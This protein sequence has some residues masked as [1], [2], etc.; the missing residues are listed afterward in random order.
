MTLSEDRRSQPAGLVLAG[1]GAPPALAERLRAAAQRLAALT[2]WPLRPFDPAL[3]PRQ[4]LQDLGEGRSTAQA[5][6]WLAP[7][8]VDPGLALGEGPSWAEA[9]GAWRQPTL[10]ILD[11]PQLA[12]GWPAAATALLRQARVPLVGLL[13]WGGEW[14][15]ERRRQDGLPWLGELTAAEGGDGEGEL[16]VLAALARRWRG[17]DLL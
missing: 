12:S 2:A 11:G 16:A 6:A 13:Q 7:L 15:P 8:S 9:L 3:S 5:P 10:L 1:V 17:L 14:Q 4:A